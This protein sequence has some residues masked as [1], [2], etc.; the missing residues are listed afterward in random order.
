M[1]SDANDPKFLFVICQNGTESA[2]RKEIQ[3]S[4]ENLKLAFSRPGFVTFKVDPQ[5]SFPEKF[6]LKSALARTVGWSLGRLEG[7]DGDGLIRQLC[8][9]FDLSS[10]E[11]LHVWQRDA[12]IPG[13]RGFVP[14]ITPLAEEVGQRILAASGA[15]LSLNR[16]TAPDA[17]VFD[18]VLV[19][20]NQWWSGYHFA[21]S[22]AGRWPGGVPPFDLSHDVIS[23]AYWKARE[24]LLWSGIR[25]GEGDWCA[26]IGS[27]P[28][29]CAQLLLEFGANVIGID[30]AEMDASILEHP[31]FTHIRKR[32][33]EVKKKELREVKWLFA[34]LNIVPNYTLD[35]VAEIVSNAQVNVQGMILTMKLPDLQ[36]IEEVPAL[37]NRVREMGFAV[38]KVRQLAFNRR[39]ICLAAARDRY[40]LRKSRQLPPRESA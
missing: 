29:G 19:E 1:N 6:T 21:N 40:V 34:D 33:R 4:H 15:N 26:E 8:A 31:N 22:V 39:E 13:H 30:P 11:H 35:T 27:A 25:V 2:V 3:R 20:P 16:I 28:G 32:G 10:F 37:M 18:L 7:E 5:G 17:K 12:A 14:G 36:L 23:R 24:A 38:V 9:E